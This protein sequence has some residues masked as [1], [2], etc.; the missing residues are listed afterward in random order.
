MTE[1]VPAGGIGAVVPE[2]N[3][4]LLRL[5]L[6]SERTSAEMSLF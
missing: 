1:M 5:S 6:A 3:L 4:L 2:W